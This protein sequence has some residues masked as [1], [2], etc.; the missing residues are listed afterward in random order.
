MSQRV[1]TTYIKLT[2]DYE[3]E[4]NAR[5]KAQIDVLEYVIEGEETM[6]LLKECGEPRARLQ[7]GGFDYA[8]EYERASRASFKRGHPLEN[9]IVP[10]KLL[11]PKE[12][13]GSAEEENSGKPTIEEWWN[14]FCHTAGLNYARRK[15]SR[16]WQYIISDTQKFDELIEKGY[17]GMDEYVVGRKGDIVI[18]RMP[19]KKR[20]G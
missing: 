10:E 20:R 17:K 5:T 7:T 4:P 14:K 13:D 9:N 15:H 18:F 1:L 3:R 11:E 8:G 12:D 19:C 6:D 16:G 2:R